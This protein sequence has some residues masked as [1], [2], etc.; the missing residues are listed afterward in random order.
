MGAESLKICS[1][2]NCAK[3]TETDFYVC[4][5]TR[6]S[7]CKACTIRINVRHQKRNRSWEGR[8]VQDD[9]KRAYMAKYYAE[10]KEKYAEYRRRFKEKHPDYHKE[11]SRELKNKKNA[12]KPKK[13][14]EHSK[15]PINKIC[16]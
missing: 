2:C 9:E 7:E 8:S 13:V 3:N 15:N 12:R 6:R 1:K 5:G 16:L 11:Y 4:K 14:T 10:H